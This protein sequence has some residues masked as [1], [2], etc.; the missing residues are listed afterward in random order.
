MAVAP[1][2]MVRLV[3]EYALTQIPP[4]KIIMGIPNYGYDWSLPFERGITK[5]RLIG[6]VE[7]PQI[8]AENGAE[9]LYSE[10]AQSPFFN[11]VRDGISHEVWF[12]DVRSISA[13]IN[14]AKE[15]NLFGVGYWNLMRPFR[16]NWL[17]LDKTNS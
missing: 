17:L 4:E 10:V 14:L 13:K 15:Y 11:Y 1:L 6:N 2:N 12:E 8:A 3:V 7:A 9:I 5:A 16:A